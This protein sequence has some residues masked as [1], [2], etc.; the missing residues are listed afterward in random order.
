MKPLRYAPGISCLVLSL[1]SFPPHFVSLSFPVTLKRAA[2]LSLSRGLLLR[3]FASLCYRKSRINQQQTLHPVAV[4]QN[5]TLPPFILLVVSRGDKSQHKHT[6]MLWQSCWHPPFLPCVFTFIQ[7]RDKL[8]LV[9]GATGKLFPPGVS[10]SIPV[11]WKESSWQERSEGK[12]KTPWKLGSNIIS[13]GQHSCSIP[14]V[15]DCGCMRFSHQR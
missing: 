2:S 11:D 10:V 13:V 7:E 6:C 12:G 14:V 3:C 1:L 9:N 8:T 15:F 5:K 4:C